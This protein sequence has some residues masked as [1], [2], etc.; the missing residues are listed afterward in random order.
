MIYQY[1]SEPVLIQQVLFRFKA[2]KEN[3]LGTLAIKKLRPMHAAAE[4]WNLNVVYSDL[5]GLKLKIGYDTKE[6]HKWLM[7][8][9]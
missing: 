1:S 8:G 2:I 6:L 7:S 9:I 3:Y 4:R 5:K